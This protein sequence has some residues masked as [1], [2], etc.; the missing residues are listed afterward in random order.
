LRARGRRWGIKNWTPADG[1]VNPRQEARDALAK[2]QLDTRSYSPTALQQFAACPYRFLLYAVH[3]LQPREEPEAVEELDP[4]SIGSLVHDV[5]FELLGRLREAG[6]LPLHEDRVPWAREVLKEVLDGV[7]GR[8]KDELA[9]AIERVWE[10]NLDTIRADLLVWIKTL[11]AESTWVPTHFE[12][13]FGLDHRDV[14]D[15]ASRGEPVALDCGLLLRGA[16]DVVERD[17]ARLRVTD[18]KTG[19]A[20]VKAG[21]VVQGGSVLQPVLYALVAE[22]LFPDA[23][24]VSG[25]LDFC[26]SKGGFTQRDILLDD[27]ARESIQKVAD[28]IRARLEAADLPAAPDK[29]ACRWCDYRV[30]CGP[31]EERR[32]ARK[33]KDAVVDL[34]RLRGLP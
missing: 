21:A 27:L 8:Y 25:R 32:T 34:E 12:L 5:L 16:I 19:R 22:R 24:V 6:A 3:R 9:P 13:S 31:S 30:V 29:D 18:H 33:R 7:A 26:T 14:E 4:R 20:R 2:H 28:T 15:E 17:G 1:L 10:D 11:A 23:E